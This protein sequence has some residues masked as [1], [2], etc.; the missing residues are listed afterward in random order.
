MTFRVPSPLMAGGADILVVLNSDTWVG[1]LYTYLGSP[2]AA[3]SIQIV[4]DGCD[5]GGIYISSDFT[6]GSEFQLTAINDGRFVGYGGNG[7][8]GAEDYAQYP[9]TG[10]QGENGG[11]AV[12]SEG[13]TVNIDIDD[14]YLFGGGGGGGGA[15]SYHVSSSGSGGGG[16]GCG[17]ANEDYT[18]YGFYQGT[19]GDPGTGIAPAAQA[20]T[21]GST[22]G[23]GLGGNG[24]GTIVATAVGGDGGFWGEAGQPGYGQYYYAT[25]PNNHIAGYGGRGGVAGNAFAPI[26]GSAAVNFNGGLTETQLRS[27]SRILGET[28]GF[29]TAALSHGINITDDAGGTVGWNY[30]NTG[31]L[32]YIHSIAGNLVL[33]GYYWRD[34]L[35]S[36]TRSNFTASLYEIRRLS[37]HKSTSSSWTSAFTEDSW[38]SA[39]ST[40]TV[41]KTGTPTILIVQM[42]QIR[43]AQGSPAYGSGEPLAMTNLNANIKPSL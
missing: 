27:Q 22:S 20:G 13:W 25:W 28:A 42:V 18:P 14:G 29:I 1:D 8:D 39:G 38:L 31:E 34:T 12:S 26:S 3:A 5:V 10:G 37:S 17:M 41:S 40:R 23:Q 4:A 15:S 30:Y 32:E 11:H 36:Y 19:G 24:G 35:D 6:T 9:G 21:N 7:G 33:D 16:G 43:R 2:A